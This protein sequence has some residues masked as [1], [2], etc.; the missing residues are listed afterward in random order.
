VNGPPVAH[1]RPRG[2]P[3]LVFGLVVGGWLTMRV[4]LWQPPFGI[5]RPDAV[6]A[7]AAAARPN[8]P[9]AGIAPRLSANEPAL[10]S[11]PEPNHAPL[12]RPPGLLMRSAGDVPAPFQAPSS[13]RI[14]V[15]DMLLSEAFAHMNLAPG[16]V[17]QATADDPPVTDALATDEPLLGQPAPQPD[18][19]ARWSGDA[20][21]L[22]R[23]GGKG[24]LAAG[25][26]T[27]GRSQAGAVLRY[28]LASSSLHRPIAYARL[29]R[30]LAGARE[31]DVAAGIALR[32][33]G[34]LPISVAV[35]VRVSER[36]AG[37]EA[38]PAAFAVTE[39]PQ[40]DLPLGLR[41]EVYAQ[42]GY[43]GGRFATA[44]ADGQTEI[45]ARL[46]RFGHAEVRAG[47]AVW[48]G[49]QEGAARL[50]VGPNATASISLGEARARVALG[51]RLRVAGDAAPKSGPALT[52][53]AGF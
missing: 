13:P 18:N 35:E 28:R 5:P 2:E 39:L 11:D 51:Y 31:S 52:I 23:G 37:R 8:P 7:G 41:A 20:W 36:P 53:S 49:A 21:L 47:G 24:P 9:L 22:W 32:P 40:L 6:L 19:S 50:D 25:Q 4:M 45:D 1:H 16:I 30:A 29:T 33:V 15:Q 14:I 17:A 12:V 26:P 48:G 46:G 34:V 10:A 44:F 3:L 42:A 43:V 27:Y 38:R